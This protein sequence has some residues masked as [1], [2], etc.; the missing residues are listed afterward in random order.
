M[1]MSRRTSST[2]LAEKGIINIIIKLRANIPFTVSGFFPNPST[3]S[4]GIL[5]SSHFPVPWHIRIN[6]NLCCN[7][8]LKLPSRLLSFR[9]RASSKPVLER[10]S[11]TDFDPSDSQ[12]DVANNVNTQGSFDC[13]MISAK[14]AHLSDALAT[15]DLYNKI[16]SIEDLC[17]FMECHVFAVLNFMWLLKA[18][19]VEFTCVQ[20]VWSPNPG[21]DPALTRF[22][23]EIVLEEESDVSQD[24]SSYSSHYELYLRAMEQ[25]G[26][27]TAPVKKLVALLQE[28]VEAMEAL[29]SCRNLIP[30]PAYGHTRANLMLLQG[31]RGQTRTVRIAS[32]FTFGREDA[33]PLMFLGILKGLRKNMSEKQDIHFDGFEY[34]LERHIELDG[35]DHGPLALRMVETACGTSPELWKHAEAAAIEALEERHKLWNGVVK[36]ISR[37]R[38]SQ[39][40]GLR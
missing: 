10:T 22:I 31:Q 5:E 13:K 21:V 8:K 26:A 4:S 35:D 11:D 39:H 3:N 37:A 40:R 19:Q 34:Y 1:E 38:T 6:E 17:T 16:A 9:K 18:L 2:F 12:D 30:E 32:A 14:T 28:G 20:E 29:E 24:G 23:N 15:H 33:I 25:V 27:D 7:M 36:E